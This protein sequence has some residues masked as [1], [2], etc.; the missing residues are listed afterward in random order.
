MRAGHRNETV[1]WQ[2]KD[3]PQTNSPQIVNVSF[4]GPCPR[5]CWSVCYCWRISNPS[6]LL[7]C[8]SSE[9]D[10]SR[11]TGSSYNERVPFYMC[12]MICQNGRLERDT[13]QLERDL[14]CTLNVSWSI[15]FSVYLAC[16]LILCT[17]DDPFVFELP[18]VMWHFVVYMTDCLYSCLA[19]AL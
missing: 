6:F 7:A 14:V 2:D 18:C 11:L 5:L 10:C 15:V 1:C 17:P 8:A 4:E 12:A 9:R 19:F 3:K 13:V 16:Y